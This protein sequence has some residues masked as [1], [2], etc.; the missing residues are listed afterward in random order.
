MSNQSPTDK[1]NAPTARV[2]DLSAEAIKVWGPS[3]GKAPTAYE[4]SN[5]RKFE[6]QTQDAGIYLPQT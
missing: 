1:T 2:L 4:F 3:W 5:G 6:L